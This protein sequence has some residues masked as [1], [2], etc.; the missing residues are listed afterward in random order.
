MKVSISSISMVGRQRSM[1]RKIVAGVTLVADTKHYWDRRGRSFRSERCGSAGRGDDNAHATTDQIV[2]QFRQSMILTFR[3]TV[4]HRHILA[5]DKTGFTEA[6]P[7]RGQPVGLFASERDAEKS[8]HRHRRLLR[9]CRQRPRCCR[10]ADKR[11][12]LA[13]LHC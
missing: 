9:A 12:E 11:N 5:L 10:A 3:P 8:D 4:L 13:P 2:G 6:P 7:K 1:A